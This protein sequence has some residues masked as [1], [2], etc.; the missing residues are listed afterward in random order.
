MILG[1][2]GDSFVFGSDLSDIQNEDCFLYH[3]SSNCTYSALI[4]KTINAEYY[5]TALPGQGNKVIADDILRA[6]AQHGNNMLYVINWSWIDRYE[7]MGT[8]RP[9]DC[10][11]WCS[12]LPGQ[13]DSNSI[14]YYKNF[15]TDID[16]KLSNLMY[17]SAAVDALVSNRCNFLITYMDY[18]LFDKTYHCPPSIDYLQSKLQKYMSTYQGKNFLDWSIAN[19][20]DV[21]KHWHPLE[22]AHEKAAEYWLPTVKTLLNTRAKEDYLHAFK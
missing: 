9:G 10:E 15:Y 18:L 6:V 19:N 7:Y 8:G 17:I 3:I 14:F 1:A 20:F 4:A 12:T 5:C 16:A 2:F 22:Q 11:G 13:D 21:S